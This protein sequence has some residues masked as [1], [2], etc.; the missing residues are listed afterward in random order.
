[1]TET[2][3]A[4]Q[5]QPAEPG[6]DLKPVETMLQALVKGLRA[7]QL[8]MP[9]N[10]VYQQAMANLKEAFDPIWEQ[11]GE[12]ELL[13]R[14]TELCVGAHPVLSQGTKQESFAWILYKDGVRALRLEPG[15]ELEEL[16]RFLQVVQKARTLPPDAEDDLLTLLW[17]QD[18]Q[19]IRYD[20]VELATEEAMPLESTVEEPEEQ[21][22]ASDA[23]EAV[24]EEVQEEERPEG[25]VRLDD[26]DSTLY[27]L[28]EHDIGYLQGEIE[29]EYS[30]DLR[31]NVLAVLFDLFELQ[32]FTTVR[33]EILS[34]VENFIPY[35]LG[36]GD[37][38]S[39]AYILREIDVVLERA[40]EV[41]PEHREAL[42][43]LPARLSEEEAIGQLLQSLDEAVVHPS[44][45]ELGGLFR[46][47]RPEALEA[48]LSWLPRL[49]NERVRE[50]LQQ[51]IQRLAQAHPEEMAKALGSEDEEVV[52]ETARLAGRLRL[53]PVV[54]ALGGLLIRDHSHPVKVAAVEALAAIGTPGAMQQLERAV[55]DDLRDV[56]VAAVRTLGQ[57]GHRAALP[58]IEQIVRSRDLRNAEL[59]EKTAFFEAYGMLAGEEGVKLL[60]PLLATG[61]F[62]KKKEDPETRAC[63][64]MALGKIGTP[65]ARDLLARIAQDKE[66]LVR[67]AASRA[68]REPK[69]G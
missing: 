19:Q 52:L 49:T 8:Y 56:R 48:I 3:A 51:A 17:E 64:A 4:A 41:I 58:R 55:A 5:E 6:F 65:A 39:V 45:E 22:S 2:Q 43:A 46:A 62:L 30:Q 68:L 34:I 36:V 37:F 61:G 40:R 63:A 12:L 25:V 13:V 1:M 53:P 66:P 35:L 7:T 47:L 69:A 50:L 20:F 59:S 38:R 18:F 44:E 26:F 11:T 54:P 60:E 24:Q 10:P 33:A 31:S 21:L 42:E 57:R 29:R 15:A 14:E 23:R 67:N 16:T 28:D 27:F 32:T 9:N